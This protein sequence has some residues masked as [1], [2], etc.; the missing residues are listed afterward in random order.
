MVP[1]VTIKVC[2]DC[3]KSVPELEVFPGPRCLD[4]HA[5]WFDSVSLS[6]HG[7]PDFAKAVRVR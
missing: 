5:K 6:Q 7:K 3:G 2:K 1:T 4:C